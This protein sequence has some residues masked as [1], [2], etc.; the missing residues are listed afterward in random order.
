MLLTVHDLIPL[1]MTPDSAKTSMWA[2]RVGAAARK[3]RR[4][5]TPSDYSKRQ[6]IERLGVHGDKI[7]VNPWAPDGK[8]HRVVDRDALQRVRQ[9]YGLAPEGPYVF[10]FG[11]EDPRKN[12][13]NILE[14]WFGL[15]P[16][17]Q[18]SCCLLLV[19]IQ[20]P[21]LSRFREQVRARAGGG[22][23]LLNGF[24]DEADLPA[25]L[26]G[27]AAL[28]YPSLSEGFGLPILDAFVCETPVLTSDAT[29]LP[30]VAGDA[31]VLVDPNQPASIRDGLVRL[32]EARQLCGELVAR[33]RERLRN[34]TWE[35]CAECLV[36]VLEQAA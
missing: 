12:T 33:G 26:S 6:L 1:E 17:L 27:S 9:K 31:A 25:L 2:K 24:A 13:A 35:R 3:A 36:Q 4:L 32:L 21:V 7:T 34:Y 19:G 30:E 20:E 8:M 14:A 10:G 5:V 16:S 15:P 28:C 18:E 22:R 23:V 29:S 11:A